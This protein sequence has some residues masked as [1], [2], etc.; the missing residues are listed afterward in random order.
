MASSDSEV[1]VL[2]RKVVEENEMDITPMIDI[3][4]L[5][6]IFFV[7]TSKLDEDT[8]VVLP[9][10]KYGAIV[11][12]KDA[13]ILSVVDVRDELPKVYKGKAVDEKVRI[14]AQSALEQDEQISEY[15]QEEIAKYPDRRAVLIQAD[16]SL[17]SRDVQRIA[18]AACRGEDVKLFYKVQEE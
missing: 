4:F 3:T 10:A 14:L 13:V 9:A 8:K 16:K 5:L 2:R 7:I 17:K 1:I 11:S 15:V 18:R 6:L 12:E